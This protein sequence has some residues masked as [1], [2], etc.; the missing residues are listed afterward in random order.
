[1]RGISRG[2]TEEGG[3]GRDI[4]LRPISKYKVA[5]ETDRNCFQEHLC[6]R[7]KS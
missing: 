5:A 7:E 1:M 2:E 3:G 4:K 6:R